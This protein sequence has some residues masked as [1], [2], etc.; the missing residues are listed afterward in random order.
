VDLHGNIWADSLH[1]RKIY[2]GVGGQCDFL[3]GAYLSEG[4]VPIIAMKSVT[5][6]GQSKI[7]DKCPEGITTTAISADPVIVVT[8]NGCFDPR[9]LSMGEHAVGIAHLAVEEERDALLKHIYDSEK[10]HKPREALK[11]GHPKGFTPMNP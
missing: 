4:G 11:D 10:F 1:A 6:R 7:L 5:S 3:R 8:E 9:G 2:S